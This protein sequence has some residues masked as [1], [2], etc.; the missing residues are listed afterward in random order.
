MENKK[1]S[2]W[3]HQESN[4]KENCVN[5]RLNKNL[6]I[7]QTNLR[8]KVVQVAGLGPVYMCDQM[9]LGLRNNHFGKIIEYEKLNNK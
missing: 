1:D 7:T 9:Y 8:L 2:C 5:K 4:W 3:K 6:I